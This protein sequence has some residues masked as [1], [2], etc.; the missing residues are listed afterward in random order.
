MCASLT[1]VLEAEPQRLAG[2]KLSENISSAAAGAI[3]P[4]CGRIG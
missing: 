1:R 3:L 4:I 2:T